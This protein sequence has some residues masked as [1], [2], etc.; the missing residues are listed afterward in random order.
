MC[1]N[2]AQL[3]HFILNFAGNYI[4]ETKIFNGLVPDSGCGLQQSLLLNY[5]AT[6]QTAVKDIKDPHGLHVHVRVWWSRHPV[7][8]T[9]MH[10]QALSV[11]IRRDS[12]L[13]V[14]ACVAGFGGVGAQ[15][16]TTM[17]KS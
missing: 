10:C 14:R 12:C 16:Q 2:F 4:N 13:C 17:Q 6:Q 3:A 1:F 8:V 15:K 11:T 9:L 7:A 5:A